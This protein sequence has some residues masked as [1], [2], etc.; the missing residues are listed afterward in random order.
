MRRILKY[1]IFSFRSVYVG[2]LHPLSSAAGS[3]QLADL[4]KTTQLW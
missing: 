2:R 3:I 1:L 4:A